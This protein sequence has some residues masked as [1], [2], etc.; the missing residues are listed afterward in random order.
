MED[1]P[2]EQTETVVGC[3][4][5][6]LYLEWAGNIS[7]PRAIPWHRTCLGRELAEVNGATAAPG[8]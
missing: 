5:Y 4:I 2:P 6:H 3:A 8:E 7:L 1:V